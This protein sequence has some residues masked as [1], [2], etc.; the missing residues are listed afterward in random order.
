MVILSQLRIRG[1]S[2][3]S[4]VCKQEQDQLAN[5]STEQLDTETLL[6]YARFLS[7]GNASPRGSVG[8]HGTQSVTELPRT[9]LHVYASRNWLTTIDR[10]LI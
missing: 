1:E 4:A 3:S 7:N 8:I 2:K 5:A 10:S 9:N 6:V